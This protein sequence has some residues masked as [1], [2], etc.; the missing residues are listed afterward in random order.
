[1][2]KVQITSGWLRQYIL[3]RG[4]ALNVATRTVIIG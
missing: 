3:K 1:M 2:H 4:G